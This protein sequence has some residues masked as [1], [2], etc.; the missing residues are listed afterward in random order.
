MNVELHIYKP[1]KIGLVT[2]N[3]TKFVKI[4]KF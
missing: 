1:G 2:V 3:P 4:N